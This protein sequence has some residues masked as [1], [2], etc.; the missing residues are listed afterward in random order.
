M[1]FNK[2]S[3]GV[4]VKKM[5]VIALGAFCTLASAQSGVT[6]SGIA[7]LY[8]NHAKSGATSSYRLQDGGSAASRFVIRGDEGLGGGLRALFFLDAG[9]SMDSGNGTM[10][11]PSLAFTRQSY[12]GLAGDWG[13]IDLGRMYNSIFNSLVEADPLKFNGN[14][15]PLILIQRP[16]AQAG[17]TPLSLR[18][19]NMVQYRG[20]SPRWIFEI[21]AGAGEASATA[22]NN[23]NELGGRLGWRDEKFYVA[24]SFHKYQSGSNPAVAANSMYQA[25]SAGVQASTHL[26]LTANYLTATSTLAEVPNAKMVN[27]GASWRSGPSTLLA[28]ISYRKVLDSPRSQLGWTV[29]YDYTLSKRTALYARL[30]HLGN[31]GTS[32]VSLAQVPVAANSG[33]SVRS[34]GMGMRHHF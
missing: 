31:R 6:I 34:F 20:P 7:D 32:A 21:G 2:F 23:A 22:V 30:L 26:R 1:N 4:S 15:S 8:I 27:V 18:T 13:R 29:G 14:F 16:D 24:Y 11:G 25:L 17:M 10:P 12:I 3:L 5:M 28:G 19:N 33:D 9:V